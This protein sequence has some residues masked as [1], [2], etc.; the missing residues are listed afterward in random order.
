MK[1]AAVHVIVCFLRAR[2]T[3][4]MYNQSAKFFVGVTFAAVLAATPTLAPAQDVAKPTGVGTAA[5]PT[6]DNPL[7]LSNDAPT[8]YTVVKGDTLWDI[9]GKFLKEP[10]RWPEIWNM[11][12]DQIK[13]P[14][15]IYPGDVVK[16]SFDAAGKPMLSIVSAGANDGPTKFSPRIRSQD[17]GQA[18][19]AI[20]A[21]AIGPF[22]T[23]P[24]VTDADA[25]KN[26]PRIVASQD[27]RVIVGAGNT[28][29]AVG[30]GADQ[31][32][33]WQVYRPGKALVDPVSKEL[34]GNEALYLGD[35]KVV[36]FGAS[37]AD[38][39]TIEIISSTQEINR[40]DRLTPAGEP[41][42]PQYSP[43]RWPDMIA[44][45]VNAARKR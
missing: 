39:S 24:L 28:V 7:L 37:P 14:H 18:I 11:N 9:S 20:P 30:I 26:A 23:A 5:K 41:T 40:G 16:L 8:I 43:L 6:K 4:Y 29:Y 17:V 45:E 44:T 25:L 12:R 3:R 1:G 19:P 22:L 35:A 13:N 42:L 27:N 33:R 15:L 31:G 38:A 21:R 10:W 2:N 34:L 36:R 32:L